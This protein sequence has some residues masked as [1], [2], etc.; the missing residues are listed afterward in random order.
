MQKAANFCESRLHAVSTTVSGGKG[1]L[2]EAFG[3]RWIVLV[4]SRQLLTAE[5]LLIHSLPWVLHTNQ[6][7]KTEP[8]I[9]IGTGV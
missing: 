1:V 6:L 4:H 7:P 9:A 8:L 3:I 2:M 5:S